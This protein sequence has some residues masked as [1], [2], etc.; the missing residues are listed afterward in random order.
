LGAKILEEFTTVN[1]TLDDVYK[2]SSDAKSF[3]SDAVRNTEVVFKKIDKLKKLVEENPLKTQVGQMEAGMDT[4]LRTLSKMDFDEVVENVKMLKRS[5]DK[6]ETS[7]VR[8]RDEKSSRGKRHSGSENDENS[9]ARRRSRSSS[10]DATSADRK[11][12]RKLSKK[13]SRSSSTSS[14]ENDVGDAKLLTM[15]KNVAKILNTV[16]ELESR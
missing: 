7:K 12:R 8:S 11:K 9:D 1:K 10:N 2:K 13:R 5:V 16:D 6:M 14:V 3:S 15:D 4:V